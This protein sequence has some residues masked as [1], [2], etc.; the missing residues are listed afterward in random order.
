MVVLCYF[1]LNLFISRLTNMADKKYDDMS[2]EEKQQATA[3]LLNRI[4]KNPKS[5]QLITLGPI[6]TKHYV[7]LVYDIEKQLGP[8]YKLDLL[9]RVEGGFILR[10]DPRVSN[11]TVRIVRITT[12]SP[13]F[14]FEGLSPDATYE[15]AFEGATF[16]TISK[17]P[18]ETLN[19][20]REEIAQD[21]KSQTDTI[22]SNKKLGAVGKV[23][24]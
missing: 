22:H 1:K 15:E 7:E 16:P 20:W 8:D 23:I 12:G 10:Q 2:R 24:N 14:M 17:I 6:T 11:K 13:V 3:E 19:K 18:F 21:I 5:I 9:P 4:V